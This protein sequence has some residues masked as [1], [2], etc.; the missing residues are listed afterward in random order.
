[1]GQQPCILVTGAAG[2]VGSYVTEAARAAGFDTR[3]L[4]R[5]PA[6]GIDWAADLADARAIEKLPLDGVTVVIHCAAA[7]PSRS[8]AFG[9]DNSRAA[10]AFVERLSRAPSVNRV[11]NISSVSVYKKP[12]RGPW[13]MTE[14]AETIDMT[15]DSRETYAGSKRQAELAFETLRQNRIVVRHIRPSSIYGRRMADTTLLPVLVKSAQSNE[16]LVLRGPRDYRQNF[17]HVKDVAALAVR[18]ADLPGGEPGIVNA[19][20]NDTYGLFELAAMIRSRFNSESPILDETEE[21]D[22]VQPDFDNTSAKGL[23]QFRSLRDHLSE[24]AA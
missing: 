11:V 12:D 5:K 2:F 8:Q 16:P 20:S 15:S 1:M 19:F 22:T 13:T 6:S 14:T 21:G 10:V 18:L 9:H 3:T 24:A 17:V 4:S 7:V 23:I